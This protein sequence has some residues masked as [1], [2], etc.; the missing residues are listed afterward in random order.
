MQMI[1]GLRTQT[2]P[3]PVRTTLLGTV[4][5]SCTTTTTT[6]ACSTSSTTTLC[7][8]TTA[9]T[10]CTAAT[11][12]EVGPSWDDGSDLDSCSD[13][14]DRPFLHHDDEEDADDEE[15]VCDLTMKKPSIVRS[16]TTIVGPLGGA[17]FPHEGWKNPPL[18]SEWSEPTDETREQARA[19]RGGHDF[20]SHKLPVEDW[21]ATEHMSWTNLPPDVVDL[22][23]LGMLAMFY[24]LSTFA[25]HAVYTDR[26]YKS[27]HDGQM[28]RYHARLRKT[29][30]RTYKKITV[31]DIYRFHAFHILKMCVHMPR[32]SLY[33][34]PDCASYNVGVPSFSRYMSEYRYRIV[35]RF[36]SAADRER[37]VREKKEGGDPLYRIRDDMD[38]V[39]AAARK[40]AIPG[41]NLSLDETMLALFAPCKVTTLCRG[42]PN[43][44]GIKFW[45]KCDISGYVFFFIIADG[46]EKSYSRNPHKPAVGGNIDTVTKGFGLGAD[47][48]VGE[49]AVLKLVRDDPP[50][51]HYVN[52]RLFTSPRLAIYLLQKR[53]I[54]YT[55]TVGRKDK[56]VR[57]SFPFPPKTGG[58]ERKHPL[59]ISGRADRKHCYRYL[60]C[61]G[62]SLLASSWADSSLCFFLTTAYDA[63]EDATLRRKSKVTGKTHWVPGPLS[64]RGYNGIMGGV[65]N[66]NHMGALG[67][68]TLESTIITS[69][70]NSKTHVG[71]VGYAIVNSWVCYK[72]VHPKATRWDYLMQLQHLM[73]QYV[74]RTH[75]LQHLRVIATKEVFVDKL[76]DLGH[77]LCKMVYHKDMPAIWIRPRAP[78]RMCHRRSTG[79]S[80][81]MMSGQKDSRNRTHYFCPACEITV[82]P[83][84]NH[85]VGAHR[86]GDDAIAG[87]QKPEPTAQLLVWW[88]LV[89]KLPTTE[90]MQLMSKV[91]IGSETFL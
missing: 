33:F 70:W 49:A 40:Y 27:W 66:R 26:Y 63:T 79:R 71:I 60:Q 20:N 81:Q 85:R 72:S 36:Y 51:T 61:Y 73:C 59:F 56:T 52:D 39:N 35:K 87:A 2:T 53:G 30:P 48:T 91:L 19:R 16:S 88:S 46:N 90:R 69:R 22:S 14:E 80:F 50:G 89:Q 64:G 7:T 18:A 4:T 11:S 77:R 42:K 9:F 25:K 8:S 3:A 29:L 84:C 28:S 1:G 13:A 76:S 12:T 47:A 43:P 86:V 38:V 75:Y 44:H 82:H 55:G 74:N 32:D 24:P 15:D 54:F 21:P 17:A 37:A 58:S 10:S 83:W 78:C 62:G 57:E 6:T 5:T 23:P 45:M 67:K 31:V 41:R 65:D 68:I 34:G